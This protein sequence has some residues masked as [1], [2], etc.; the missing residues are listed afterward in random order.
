MDH[1]DPNQ[2]FFILGPCV[3]ESYD[4]AKEIALTIQ[5][6]K[7]KHKIQIIYKGSYLKANRSSH[8]SYRG[9]GLKDGL[10]ILS[11]IKEEFN[12]P[13]ITDV[14]ESNEFP[15]I[16]DVIDIIQ[17]PAFLSRQTELLEKAGQTN[18]WV[19]IK[20]AQFMAPWDVLNAYEKVKSTGNDKIF[21]TERGTCFGYNNLVVDFR[22]MRYL[23]NHNKNV[24][25]DA[26]HSVQLPSANSTSSGG[27][28][29]YAPYLA[30]AAASIGVNGFFFETHPNPQK[31]LCDGPNSI[32]LDELENT[33]EQ[34]IAFHK[35]Y[36]SKSHNK[37]NDS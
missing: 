2:I 36:Q 30:Q 31:A 11:K 14:H 26:T 20:K 3:V 34:I 12:F 28:R 21:I 17:I 23:L 16:K 7:K 10:K 32:P 13:I 1:F 35:L 9:P 5:N 24:I 6:I 19:N 22:G 37:G 33:I 15:K 29:E 18:L 27:E 8:L 4:I 25:F